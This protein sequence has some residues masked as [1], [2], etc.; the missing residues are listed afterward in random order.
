M[1]G[2]RIKF[3]KE[4]GEEHKSKAPFLPLMIS[5]EEIMKFESKLSQLRGLLIQNLKK[6]V[7]EGGLM[8]PTEFEGGMV[9]GG[10]G[11]G[12]GMM[13]M[14][15]GGGFGGMGGMGGGFVGGM[16]GYGMGS[17]FQEGFYPRLN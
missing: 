10:M 17:E 15:M 2:R 9:G 4:K 1:L 16:G 14:G 11:M 12:G 8:E 3:V 5:D 13:G 7:L 6:A